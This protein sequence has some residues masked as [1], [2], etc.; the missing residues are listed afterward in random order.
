MWSN[1]SNIKVTAFLIFP[2]IL[3]ICGLDDSATYIFGFLSGGAL[4]LAG[5]YHWILWISLIFKLYSLSYH[6]FIISI[7]MSSKKKKRIRYSTFRT[8]WYLNLFYLKKVI[9][10]ALDLLFLEMN[11]SSI[12]FRISIVILEC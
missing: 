11:N 10:L 5:I 7:P 3:M 12:L 1:Y 2:A 6:N 9:F 4:V 8:F